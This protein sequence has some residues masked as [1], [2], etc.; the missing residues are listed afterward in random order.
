PGGRGRS[1]GK[2]AVGPRP[3]RPR[4]TPGSGRAGRGP[5]VRSWRRLG[6]VRPSILLAP[7]LRRLETRRP[8]HVLRGDRLAGE[9]VVAGAEFLDLVRVGC[10]QVLLLR[11]V[12]GQVEEFHDLAPALLLGPVVVA[13]LAVEHELP[14]ADA[15]G[16]VAR[17]GV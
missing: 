9:G 4:P 13:A 3:G 7:D 5:C 17:R 6:V 11:K 8:G 1:A 2:P 16:P 14:V 12:L 10:G 15:E